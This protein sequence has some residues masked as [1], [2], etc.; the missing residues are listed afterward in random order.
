MEEPDEA[1]AQ[2]QRRRRRALQRAAARVEA[3]LR[4]TDF[5]ES[6]RRHLI[7]D[8]REACQLLCPDKLDVFDMIYVP[9]F[10]K[11]IQHYQETHRD[12]S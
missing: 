12:A 9:R 1:A 10:E 5:T 6:Q 2:R 8:A 3:L 11:A 7:A 4:T